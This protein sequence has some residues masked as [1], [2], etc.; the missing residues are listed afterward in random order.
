M[1]G[2]DSIKLPKLRG[3][4]GVSGHWRRS[5]KSFTFTVDIHLHQG[6]NPPM[7]KNRERQL[8]AVKMDWHCQKL[9]EARKAGDQAA[10]KSH[11]SA[12]F[13]CDEEMIRLQLFPR[14]ANGWK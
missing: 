2:E 1:A 13:H 11:Q 12:I 6:Y 4:I 8:Y 14:F 7:T 3:E 10:I 9:D 5:H